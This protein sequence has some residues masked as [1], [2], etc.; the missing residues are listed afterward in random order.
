VDLGSKELGAAA[1]LRSGCKLGLLSRTE[2][3]RE[4]N[5]GGVE[6]AGVG[7]DKGEN[8]SNFE[9]ILGLFLFSL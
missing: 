6:E 7:I 8:E 1:V 4:L 9:N 5:R 2:L 3:G